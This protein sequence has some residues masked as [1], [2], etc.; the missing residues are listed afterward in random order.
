MLKHPNPLVAEA[1][2][3]EGPAD[4][5]ASLTSLDSS[6]FRDTAV[7]DHGEETVAQALAI[8]TAIT[9]HGAPVESTVRTWQHAR[10]GLIHGVLVAEVGEWS[11]VMLVGDH[12]LR[13]VS[14]DHRGMIDGDGEILRSRTSFLT[15]VA[16]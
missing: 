8:L 9:V 4:Y 2:A 3:N 16:A 5:L 12:Q 15:E 14:I 6:D 7:N 10:K 11:D 13:Y 1:L